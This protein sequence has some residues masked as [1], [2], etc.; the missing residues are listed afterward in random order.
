MQSI[1]SIDWSEVWT[2]QMFRHGECRG[3]E[4]CASIWED[5]ENARKFWE[6]AKK[7]DYERSKKIISSLPVTAKSKVL[8]IGA[9]PGTLAIPLCKIARHVTAVE[10]SK[11]MLEVL[12]ENIIEQECS[13]ITCV[14][15]KWEEVDIENDLEGPYDIIIASFSL[16]MPDIRKAIENMEAA[17]S[18]DIYLYWFAGDRPWDPYARDIWPLMYD[19]EYYPIPKCDILY[20]TLYQMSIYPNMESFSLEQK[21]IFPSIEKAVDHFSGHLGIKS[22]EEKEFLGRYLEKEL[23]KENDNFV[24]KGHSTR[25]KIWWKARKEN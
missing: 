8:D 23:E 16:A 20:N 4:D 25:T 18:G 17:C 10:P 11:G 15:K 19:K 12:Q 22:V 9:G 2:E 24:H 7:N 21:D 6:M 3:S 14:E 1:Y 5:K 13:N